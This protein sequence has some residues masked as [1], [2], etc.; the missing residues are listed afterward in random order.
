MLFMSKEQTKPKS[1]QEWKDFLAKQAE[2]RDFNEAKKYPG[3]AED[4][5]YIYVK[6]PVD[7]IGYKN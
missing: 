5:I 6:K 4:A 1:L 2:Y 3:N 7:C